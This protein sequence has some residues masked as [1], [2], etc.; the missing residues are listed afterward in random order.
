MFD[1]EVEI[2]SLRTAGA[3]AQAAGEQLRSVDAAGSLPALGA[4][5]RGSRSARLAVG[6]ADTWR[7]QVLLAGKSAE[8]LGRDMVASADRYGAND[9]DAKRDLSPFFSWLQ[10]FPW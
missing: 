5:M 2:A 9:A 6:I 1:F 3:A 8:K 10:T 4:G 7:G